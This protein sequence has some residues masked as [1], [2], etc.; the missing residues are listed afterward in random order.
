MHSERLEKIISEALAKL[1][2]EGRL[3]GREDVITGVMKPSAGRGPRYLI[4]GMGPREFIKMDSNSYL[5]LSLNEKVIRAGE[6]AASE[7]GAGPGSVRF[8]HGTYAPHRELEEQ[9]ALFHGREAAII[10]SS[11]YSAVCGVLVS[12]ISADTIVI[13]DALNHNSIINAARMS[14]PK[15]KKIYR[16]L[17]MEDLKRKI[18]ESVGVCRRLLI[19]TD[20]V[21]SMRGDYPDLKK[22]VK[23]S[24]DYSGDFDEGIITVMDDSHGT[25]AYG[26]TGRGTAEAADEFGVDVII[27]TL[28][29]ALGVN[30]GYAAGSAK[31]VEYLRETSPFYIYSNPVTPGE[32]A[33]A[34]RS[35]EILDSRAGRELL[36]RLRESAGYFRR[37]LAGAGYEVLEGIHPIVAVMIRDGQKT[38]GIVEYLR[39]SGILAVGLKYP[40]VPGG[41]ECIR[42]QV[43]A[44]HTMDDIN[45]V[46]EVMKECKK[47]FLP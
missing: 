29:K 19:V 24:K 31:L 40:V 7:F 16:H 20:G 43:N 35:L 21:F 13:S 26:R 2:R 34:L 36:T 32:A 45:Y 12:L 9:L 47:R 41:D 30:G 3:K 38:A 42:M 8:I 14:R 22:L 28:G 46:L 6:K 18:E 33:A 37:E 11:A 27:S 1:A 5:G 10:F 25:G 4:E 39:G 17:D 44:C 23:L 15:E